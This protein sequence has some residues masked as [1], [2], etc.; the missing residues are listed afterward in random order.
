MA[1]KSLL[2][3]SLLFHLSSATYVL[4]DDY[5]P[6]TFFSMFSFFTVSQKR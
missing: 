5:S 6:D 3:L 2:T 1:L 4:E